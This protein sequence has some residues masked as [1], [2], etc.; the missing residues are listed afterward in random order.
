MGDLDLGEDAG[1]VLAGVLGFLQK[2]SKVRNS[3]FES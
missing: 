1:R 2:L 3:S